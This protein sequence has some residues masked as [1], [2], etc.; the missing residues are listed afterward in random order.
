MNRQ[1]GPSHV[2]ANQQ[3][4]KEQEAINRER[5]M[6][7]EQDAYNRAQAAQRQRDKYSHVQSHG[8]GRGGGA[9]NP[10]PAPNHSSGGGGEDVEIKVFVRECE[11][12]GH[13]F[14]IPS[15][16]GLRAPPQQ[17]V[18]PRAAPQRAQPQA[19]QAPPANA[20]RPSVGVVPDYILKRKQEL[21]AEQEAVR[22]ELERRQE[23]SKYPPGHRPV[24]EEERQDIL[25]RLAERKRDLE[26]ELGRLP[27][28]FDTQAIKTRRGQIEG[29]L[30]EVEAAERKFS[31][32]KQLFVPI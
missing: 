10:H 11:P 9:S 2:R 15:N 13:S 18:E 8:Y 20:P 32:K 4:I 22:S 16:G 27:I 24:S 17:R 21:R 3:L 6:L 29:E 28:R 19:K 14:V 12:D 25:S 1:E 30:A 31:V 23:A 5:R 26:L 7:D